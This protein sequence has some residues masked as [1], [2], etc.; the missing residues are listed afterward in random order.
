[1]FD[2]FIGDLARY[3]EYGIALDLD[4]SLFTMDDWP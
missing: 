4:E 1:V 3:A 2:L